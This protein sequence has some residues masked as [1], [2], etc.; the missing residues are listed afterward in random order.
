[1]AVDDAREAFNKSKEKGG[2]ECA[3]LWSDAKDKSTHANEKLNSQDYLTLLDAQSVAE[4]AR[5][6]ADTARDKAYDETHHYNDI[7][8]KKI[9]NYWKKVPSALIG[10]PLL[11][12]LISGMIGCTIGI[13]SKGAHAADASFGAGF[14]LGA[15]ISFLVGIY[16]IQKELE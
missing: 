1:R 14:L 15:L 13:A 2:L 5:N 9:R 16:R 10:F 8:S 12:G 4:S 3:R 11:Y 6:L 7:W